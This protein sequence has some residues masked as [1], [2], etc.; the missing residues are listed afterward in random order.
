M[1]RPI[2]IALLLGLLLAAAVPFPVLNPVISPVTTSLRGVSAVSATTAWVS[3]ADGTVLLTTDAGKT[4]ERK[5]V[6]DTEKLDFRDVQG[7]DARAAVIMSAGP[8][9]ASRVYRTTDGGATWKLVLQNPDADGFFDGLAFWDARRGMLIGDPVDGAF[10]LYGTEDGGASWTRVSGAPAAGQGEG[11]FAASGT[12][13][14]VAEGGFAWFGTGGVKGGRVF[15]STDWGATWQAVETPIRHDGAAAG[16]FSVAFRDGKHGVAV[17]GDYQKGGEREGTA[18][19]TDDGGLTWRVAAGAP[20][21]Y[22]S[23]VAW[24]DGKTVM[25]TGP[26]GSDISMDDG[27]TWKAWGEAGYHALSVVKGDG[28]ATGSGGR[29]GR[30]SAAGH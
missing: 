19:V 15:R 5:S 4:W 11:A 18:V 17:G 2:L 8:G 14:A 20:G 12:S 24:L 16:V 3:G 13:L 27:R 23:A 22:R 7:F 6:P 10:T 25:C 1:L 21:G 26:S 29:I 30:I 28:F 9:A